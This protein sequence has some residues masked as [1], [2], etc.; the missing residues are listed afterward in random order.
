M[1][2]KPFSLKAFFKGVGNFIKTGSVSTPGKDRYIQELK[3]QISDERM[4]NS[5]L[6]A[7]NTT[8]AAQ[9]DGDLKAEDGNTVSVP[10][11]GTVDPN[12]TRITYDDKSGLSNSSK[13]YQNLYGTYYSGYKKD[14]SIIHNQLEKQADYLKK[15]EL[16]GLDFSFDAVQQQNNLLTNQIKENTEIF[17]TDIQKVN[18]QSEKII[19]LKA[20][21]V[22]IFVIFYVCLVGLVYVL[23]AV[24][25][26]MSRNMKIAMIIVFALYPFYINILQQILYFIGAYLYAI[27]NGNV[28]TSNN[29]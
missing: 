14:E 7:Q 26:T 9:I 15:T 17:S 20:T 23:F 12:A 18:Y 27:L 6:A 28:Y 11:E 8:L 19:S 21:Y 1:G 3:K 16:T 25:T 10:S 13:A 5:T 4:R 2:R 24:N 22:Y 29:Y